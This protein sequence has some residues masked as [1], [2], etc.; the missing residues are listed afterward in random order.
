MIHQTGSGDSESED[1]LTELLAEQAFFLAIWHK[2][3]CCGESTDFS[4]SQPFSTELYDLVW[5]G[6]ETHWN[7]Q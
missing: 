2:Q 7:A 4:E 6:Q 5:E 3:S 1:E